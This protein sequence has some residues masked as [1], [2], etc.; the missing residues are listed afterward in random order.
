MR[1]RIFTQLQS[2]DQQLATLSAER[3]EVL[4]LFAEYD[5]LRELRE[6]CRRLASM[7]K[8]ERARNSDLQWELDDVENRLRSLTQSEA[9]GPSD[10]L[11]ARELTLLRDRLAHLEEQVLGQFD[12]IADVEHALADCE[13]ALQERS[14]AWVEREPSLQAQM[15]R[16]GQSFEVL[17]SERQRLTAQLPAGAAELYDDL[18]RRHRGTALAAVRNRQCSACR[19]RLPAAVFDLLAAADP[20]V[21][22]PRCGRVLYLPAAEDAA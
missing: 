9:D 6:E 4:E 2:I 8:Q 14:A 13:R 22:C 18:Q 15:E 3:A 5:R 21:R 10:P 20:L 16:V 12:R 19:A 7:L 11:V 1:L 17:Q